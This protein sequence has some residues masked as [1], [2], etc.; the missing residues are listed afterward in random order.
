MEGTAIFDRWMSM[1]SGEV[2][3][4]LIFIDVSFFFGILEVYNY[5]HLNTLNIYWRQKNEQTLNLKAC[6]NP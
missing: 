4:V 1:D 3:Y 6:V 5:T 2:I